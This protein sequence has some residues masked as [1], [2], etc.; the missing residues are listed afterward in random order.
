MEEPIVSTTAVESKAV[1]N[2]D[3]VGIKELLEK[4]LKWSQI[5]YEQNRKINS[6][7]LWMNITSWVRVLV[8]LAPLVAG[9]LFLP[10]LYKKFQERYGFLLPSNAR[11][12]AQQP[13]SS[14]EEMLKVLPLTDAQKA[15]LRG[16]LK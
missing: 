3:H 11:P 5:I 10:T 14:V 12:T 15:Q 8:I 6:K 2:N 7:L 4:N 16:M 1:P 9:I 13:P